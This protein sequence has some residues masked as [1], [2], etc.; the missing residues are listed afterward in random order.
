[1]HHNQDGTVADKRT[2]LIWQSK[3]DGQQRTFAEAEEYCEKLSLA[4]R[5]DWRLPT[6]A[7]LRTIVVREHVPTIDGRYFPDTKPDRYWTR[8][9]WPDDPDVAYTIDFTDGDDITYC[10]YYKYYAR[11]S[12]SLAR[13]QTDG[14]GAAQ[15]GTRNA[16]RL[17]VRKARPKV[18]G[19][20]NWFVV[21]TRSGRPSWRAAATSPR[22]PSAPPPGMRPGS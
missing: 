9:E 4:Q 11:G 16:V 15:G 8:S 3:D 14:R 19:P 17:S 22:R 18:D 1:M 12:N 21:W 20:D 7:E 13:A 2:G 6:L 10:K 5:W